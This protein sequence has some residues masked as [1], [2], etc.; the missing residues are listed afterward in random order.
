MSTTAAYQD[1]VVV[2]DH[3]VTALTQSPY[4]AAGARLVDNGYSAIPIAPGS[5]RPGQY[6]IQTWRN[7]GQWQRYC[8]RLPTD[9]E[10]EI[11]NGWPDAGVCVALNQDLKAIDID[12]DDPDLI[13]AILAVL[14]DF[15]R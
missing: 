14:P 9:I 10:K 3:K 4:A 11:W 6:D 5:K 13:K 2:L 15:G 8:D 1:E 12:T 7:A